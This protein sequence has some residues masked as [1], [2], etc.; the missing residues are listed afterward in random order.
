[1]LYERACMAIQSSISNFA[2]FDSEEQVYAKKKSGGLVDAI[3]DSKELV[4]AVSQAKAYR[5]YIFKN[6]FQTTNCFER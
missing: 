3:S 4:D 6:K 2:Y 1:M 5:D